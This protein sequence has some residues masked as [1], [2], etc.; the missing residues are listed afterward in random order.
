MTDGSVKNLFDKFHEA[1]GLPDTGIESVDQASLKLVNAARLLIKVYSSTAPNAAPSPA[2]PGTPSAP[3]ATELLPI[4]AAVTTS[5]TALAG[6]KFI[7]LECHTPTELGDAAVRSAWNTPIVRYGVSIR[8]DRAER[9]FGFN[10]DP[11]TPLS[12]GRLNDGEI[13]AEVS[14]ACERVQLTGGAGGGESRAS[15]TDPLVHYVSPALSVSFVVGGLTGEP[16]YNKDGQLNVV[17]GALPPRLIV[18]LDAVVHVAV[19]P[20]ATQATR[21]QKVTVTAYG[22]FKFTDKLVFRIGVPIDGELASRK[23]NP[24]ATPPVTAMRDLQ[25]TLPV[26]VATVIKM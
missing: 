10:P 21:W 20:P 15:L 14:Y 22:D 3:T 1:C 5:S 2:A 4:L 24:M 26:F 6:F 13:R 17:G 12:D 8:E 7:P 23:A 9:M 11:K 19:D 16:L 18:G 25:W